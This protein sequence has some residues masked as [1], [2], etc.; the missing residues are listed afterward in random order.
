MKLF[1]CAFCDTE[2]T[3]AEAAH[4]FQRMRARRG[5]HDGDDAVPYEERVSKRKAKRKA[6]ADE[7]RARRAASGSLDDSA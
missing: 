6:M 4:E 5:Q 3:M 1:E 2:L 7:R